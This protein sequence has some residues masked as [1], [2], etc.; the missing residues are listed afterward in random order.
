METEA[1]VIE[2]EQRAAQGKANESITTLNI[3]PALHTLLW[4]AATAALVAL[5]TVLGAVYEGGE[6]AH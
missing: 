3:P 2:R 5:M 4:S 1:T 6:T